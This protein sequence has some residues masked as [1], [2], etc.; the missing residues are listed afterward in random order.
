M[1]ADKPNWYDA[2]NGLPGLLG[3]SI[4][5]TFEVKRF[6]LFLRGVFIQLALEDTA[7]IQIFGELADFVR[8]LSGVLSSEP[9]PFAYWDKSNEAKEE[10]R[11]QI[12]Y[13]IR[14]EEKGLTVCEIKNFLNAVIAKTDTAI[15]S[16]QNSEGFLATYFYHEVVKYEPVPGKE[17]SSAKHVRPLAFQRHALPLF[18]EGYV[19]AMRVEQTAP[20]ARRLYQQVRNSGLYDKKLKMYKVNADLS[21]ESEEIGR[22][23]IF[24]DGWLE[25]ASIWLHMEYKLILELLRAG[26]YEEFYDNFRHVLIPFLQPERYGRSILEN[27]SFLVSSVHEDKSLHGQGFVARL[28]GST[29]EFLHMWLW[30]NAGERPFR[31]DSQNKLIL[32]FKPVLAGWLFTTKPANVQHVLPSGKTVTAALPAHT[33]AFNFLNATLVVCH[34]PKRR[35][36]FKTSIEA[37]HLRYAGSSKPVVISSSVIPSPYAEDVRSRKVERIDIYLK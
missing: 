23:R 15:A 14:G 33:Y 3:S 19:H 9:D 37:I 36:T 18:L 11:R 30:M 20:G 31:L 35:D 10:Y 25:N 7:E 2:L 24:P 21:N 12:Q 26:L 27:S 17:H 28:S 32:E 8:T 34:N 6:S 4:S 29:A 22:A 16:A 5:E 1:E 13:G